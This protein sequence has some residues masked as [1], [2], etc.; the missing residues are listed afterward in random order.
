MY[1][2]LELPPPVARQYAE[3]A[4]KCFRGWVLRTIRPHYPE[5]FFQP[6][7][8]KLGGRHFHPHLWRMCFHQSSLL[9]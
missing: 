5:A 7:M 8:V 6:H 4:F 3:T 2:E 9:A 1:L